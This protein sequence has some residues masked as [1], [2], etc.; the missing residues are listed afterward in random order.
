MPH[1]HMVFDLEECEQLSSLSQKS[2][3]II[4][5]GQANINFLMW[6]IFSILLRSKVGGF[7]EH[8]NVAI[9]GPDERCGEP[10]L[11]NQKQAFL[12][13]LRSL[14]W[15]SEVGGPERDMPLTVIRV[16][17]RVGAEQS[18]EMAI[19]WVHTDSYIYIHDDTL[20]L[21]KNWEPLVIESLY[22]NNVAMVYPPPFYTG[23][24]SWSEYQGRPKL[25]F[26]H[27]IS[28]CMI[29]RKPIFTKCG[30][31]WTGYHFASEF[32]LEE[33]IK[34]MEVFMNAHKP[35]VLP[36]PSSLRCG[37]ASYDIGSWVYYTLRKEGYEINPV[38][39]LEVHH[40]IS[41]SWS[42]NRERVLAA[43]D[44]ILAL[45][46]EIKQHP[47]YWELYKKFKYD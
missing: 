47:E 32:L 15:R 35:N 1:P 28:P 12:E 6:S 21:T 4:T 3:V 31:R 27:T 20:W 8:I 19:P 44:H 2:T 29:C 9:N 17:S 23:H 45:E 42:A 46:A 38:S 39:N 16:W 22:K 24:L 36:L 7:M 33:K 26:P 18:V 30:V 25:N 40:F 37:Y 11:Q 13:E 10:T 34:D 14:K 43:Q 5:T 41:M